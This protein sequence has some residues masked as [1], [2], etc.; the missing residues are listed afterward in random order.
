M[1]MIINQFQTNWTIKLEIIEMG[2][3]EEGDTP[4]DI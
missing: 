1:K 3:R 2:F 4:S